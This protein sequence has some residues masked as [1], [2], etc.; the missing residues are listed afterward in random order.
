MKEFLTGQIRNVALAGHSHSGKTSL[1][2]AILYNLKL[3][4]RLGKV[5][6]GNTVSDYDPEEVRRKI[7][8]NASLIPP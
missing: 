2:E 5:E 3:S 6:D 1:L 8:I 7:S 4:D